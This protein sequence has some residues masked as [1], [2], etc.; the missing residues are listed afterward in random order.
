MK[1]SRTLVLTQ[2]T[3]C[4]ILPSLHLLLT[5]LLYVPAPP[6]RRSFP[7]RLAVFFPR[8]TTKKKNNSQQGKALKYLAALSQTKEKKKRKQATKKTHLRTSDAKSSWVAMATEERARRWIACPSN[9]RGLT[10][11][12]C[13]GVFAC[14]SRRCR[15]WWRTRPWRSRHQKKSCR[16]TTV[17]G[18]NQWKHNSLTLG[19]LMDFKI[20]LEKGKKNTAS[21]TEP[22]VVCF[23][24]F[25]LPK[26]A[27]R[28]LTML[29]LQD[30]GS[31][32]R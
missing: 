25:F 28:G 9:S 16:S 26:A 21:L 2:N 15:R 1:K 10:T 7:Q 23:L 31:L 24:F 4:F 8:W 3:L 6:S 17:D 11:A 12:R 27:N 13:K 5:H 18:H 32:F 22:F 30:R 14:L 19:R 20:Q 29:F